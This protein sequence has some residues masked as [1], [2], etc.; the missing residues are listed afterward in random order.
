[1]AKTNAPEETAPAA[2]L[3][4]IPLPRVRAKTR[5]VMTTLTEEEHA[6][7]RYI[8]EHFRAPAAFLIRRMIL[9]VYDEL[10]PKPAI[11]IP[12]PR[13]RN[14]W[15]CKGNPNRDP[16]APPRKRRSWEPPLASFVPESATPV[17][18]D[19]L[20]QRKQDAAPSVVR[21]DDHEAFED[22][23]TGERLFRPRKPPVAAPPTPPVVVHVG[24]QE[25]RPEATSVGLVYC[26]G[27]L[28]REAQEDA[29]ELVEPL[30]TREEITA[31]RCVR[32]LATAEQRPL[33]SAPPT[34]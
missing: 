34:R 4:R 25:A 30:F 16:N 14:P 19:E 33:Y 31:L 8:M 5:N 32:C 21:L 27:C 17:T 15:G 26:R 24:S 1:M 10:G 29:V 18:P 11:P 22:P 12:E 23:W 7:L 2:Q 6:K 20:L 9:E 3:E 28:P 13:V